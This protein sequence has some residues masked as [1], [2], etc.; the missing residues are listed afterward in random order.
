MSIDFSPKKFGTAP[1]AAA[2]DERPKAEYWINLG[3][4]LIHI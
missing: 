1:T 3:L 4:S 2:Q